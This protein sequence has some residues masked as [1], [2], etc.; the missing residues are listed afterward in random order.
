MC[1]LTAKRRGTFKNKPKEKCVVAPSCISRVIKAATI[2]SAFLSLNSSLYETQI[3][4]THIHTARINYSNQR[5]TVLTRKPPEEY[6]KI[7]CT[8]MQ[9]EEIHI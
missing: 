6:M 9:K 7:H 5:A 3:A 2:A 1:G 8:A 4:R